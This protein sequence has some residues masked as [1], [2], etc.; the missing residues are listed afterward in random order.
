[1]RLLERYVDAQ[2]GGP[3]KGWYRIVTN[4]Y[5]AR[6]VINEGKL[7]VVM[8]IETSVPVRLHHQARRPGPVVHQGVH[9]PAA[10]PGPPDGRL[11]DG[12]GQQVRQRAG[13]RRRRRR[14]D[15]GRRELRQLP[16]DRLVLGHAALPGGVRHRRA[17]PQPAHGARTPTRSRSATRCSARSSR[18]TASPRRSRSRCTARRRTATTAASPTSGTTPIRGMVKRHMIFDPD[19][20]SVLARKKALDLAESLHYPGV[21]SSHSWSTPGRVPPDLQARRVHHAVRRRQ[22]RVR[23]QVAQAPASGPTRATTSASGTA[24]T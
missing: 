13:R 1:M 24:R 10:H 16:G 11:A 9:R 17:R 12:A 5:Q 15:R 4:P 6:R 3:G 14:A 7:A 2:Y 18:S 22:H 21:V 19:H 8:G 20:M 23:G